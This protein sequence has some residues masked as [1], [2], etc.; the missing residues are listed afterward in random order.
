MWPISE[1]FVD[2]LSRGHVVASRVDLLV[3]NQ[4]IDLT[5]AGVVVDGKVECSATDTRR[6]MSC[7]L[8]DYVGDLLPFDPQDA[9]APA[10]SE[11]RFWRGIDYQDGTEELVPIGT[12]RFTQVS[13][14]AP[15][16]ELQGYDRSWVVQG[17]KLENALT[18]AAGTNYIDAITSVLETAYGPDLETNFPDTEEVTASMVFDAD[19]D[20]WEIAQTLA[21]NLEHDLYFDPLGIAT[22][23]PTPD[24]ETTTPIWTFDESSVVNIG[25]PGIALSWDITDAVNVVIVIG[26]NTDN[27]A[28]FRG[29]AKD[30]NPSSPTRYDGPVGRRPLT[31]RDEKIT[32]PFQATMRAR[33]ELKRRIGLPQSLTIP[34]MVNPAFE[35]GDICEIV[36]ARLGNTKQLSVF[37]KFSVP[38]RAKEAMEITTRQRLVVT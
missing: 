11:L 23:T 14:P 35:I 19:S 12:F 1:K 25:L 3:D 36:S 32:G 38:L 29:V 31:I 15:K 7:S 34:S 22:M 24:P 37:D 16:I 18:I 26:E 27:T 5:A 10:G 28:V 13:V 9:L 8:V 30:E 6:T 17:A 2:A 4:I 20:P 33:V 21:A